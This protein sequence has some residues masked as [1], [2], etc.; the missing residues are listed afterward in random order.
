MKKLITVSAMA[1]LAVSAFGQGQV[2]FNNLDK[3][4]NVLYLF[5]DAS[6]NPLSGTAASAALLG[7]PSAGA[8]AYVIAGQVAGNLTMLASPIAPFNSV[9]NFRTGAAAGYVNTAGDAAR[10]VP[11]VAYG[12]QAA[13]QMVVWTGSSKDW[14]TAW[15]AWKT[16]PTSTQIAVSPMWTVTTTLSST[17]PNFPVNSG[18]AG[19]PGTSLTP[20]IPEP[21]TLAL[22]GLAGAALLIFRRRK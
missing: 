9:L 17:D 11:G 14:T 15:S 13:L 18:L 10:V 7:G 6:G 12:A 4:N 16:D 1:L 22:A 3:N 20:T 19:L 5:K 8:T 2:N 21:S